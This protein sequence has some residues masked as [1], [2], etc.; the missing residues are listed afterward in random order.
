MTHIQN[1]NVVPSNRD[2]IACPVCGG[3]I[4]HGSI[5]FTVKNGK[6]NDGG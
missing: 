4:E 3:D 5:S 6:G 1:L 2:G